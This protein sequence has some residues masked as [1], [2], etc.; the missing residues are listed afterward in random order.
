MRTFALVSLASALA[1]GGAFAQTPPPVK[2]SPVLIEAAIGIGGLCTHSGVGTSHYTC[3]VVAAPGANFMFRPRGGPFIVGLGVALVTS[4]QDLTPA[5]TFNF[6]T[7]DSE[8]SVGYTMNHEGF[9]SFKI[10]GKAFTGPTP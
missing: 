8:I 7:Q 3:K 2:P 10:A 6:G 1:V 5:G 9:I 4:G